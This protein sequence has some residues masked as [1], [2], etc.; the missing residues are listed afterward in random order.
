MTTP[1]LFR[2]DGKV[3]LVSGGAGIVGGA[4]VRALAESGATVVSASRDGAKC[5]AHAGELRAAGLKVEGESCDFADEHGMTALRGRILARHTRL[6]IL[7]NNAVARAG[8]DLDQTT[9][10]EWESVMRLNSTGLFL[11]CRIFAEPMQQQRSGSIVNIA[12]IYGM[13]GP[14]FSIYEGTPL[15][16]SVSYSFAKGGMINLTRY[17]ASY[18]AP[19][20]IRVN[21][22]SPGGIQTP[23][24]PERFVAQ[25]SART[26]MK[27]MGTEDDLTGPAVFLASEA[28][29]YITGH[30]L[31][32]DGGWTAV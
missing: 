7:V 19:W 6:D 10:A 32:V 18:Y 26:P 22:L 1:E 13:V 11:A 29:R 15:H 28:S 5:E 4:I 12:S 20:N 3:A 9:G 24:H 21:A 2:L 30:N 16:N 14:D 17:L 31:P 27:R 23:A 8:G 25:Y